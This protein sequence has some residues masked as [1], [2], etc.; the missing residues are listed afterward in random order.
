MSRRGG[1]EGKE[2]DEEKT[3]RSW[4]LSGNWPKPT[5]YELSGEYLPV[6]RRGRGRKEERGIV[7]AQGSGSRGKTQGNYKKKKCDINPNRSAE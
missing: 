5:A 1:L 4:V 7:T 2:I 3:R 6:I